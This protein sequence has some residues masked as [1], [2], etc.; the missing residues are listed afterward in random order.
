MR[1]S[2]FF[3]G[4]YYKEFFKCPVLSDNWRGSEKV[5]GIRKLVQVGLLVRGHKTAGISTWGL[6]RFP[7]CCRDNCDKM[8]TQ[9]QL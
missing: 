2:Y 1:C 7:S 6:F 9:K 3:F 4:H 8:S 5:D